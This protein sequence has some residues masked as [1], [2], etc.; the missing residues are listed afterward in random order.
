MAIRA[1]PIGL[2]W[3]CGALLAAVIREAV[4]ADGRAIH[5]LTGRINFLS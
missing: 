1:A 2:A 4:S 5:A 3:H